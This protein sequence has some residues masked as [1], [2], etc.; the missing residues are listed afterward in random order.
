VTAGSADAVLVA[1]ACKG[2]KTAFAELV[3]R[4]Y[5]LL[6]TARTCAAWLPT[7]PLWRR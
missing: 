1:A 4:H 5:P 3:D 7:A 6:L 2:D